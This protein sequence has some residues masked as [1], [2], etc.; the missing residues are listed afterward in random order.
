M[1]TYKVG[2]KK[3]MQKDM[4]FHKN[5]NQKQKNTLKSGET[6]IRNNTLMLTSNLPITFKTQIK[7]FGFP[8]SPQTFDELNQILNKFGISFNIEYVSKSTDNIEYILKIYSPNINDKNITNTYQSYIRT[9]LVSQVIDACSR[10][11]LDKLT[12]WI[13]QGIIKSKS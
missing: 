3:Y 9:N 5:G 8:G 2:L 7:R 10:I 11:L 12:I 13:S 6:K 1:G 4:S